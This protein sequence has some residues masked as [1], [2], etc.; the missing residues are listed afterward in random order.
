[1]IGNPGRAGPEC[2]E[3]HANKDRRPDPGQRQR[4]RLSQPHEV[5]QPPGQTLCLF[6]LGEGRNDLRGERARGPH[7]PKP[8]LGMGRREDAALLRE[9][10]GP[11]GCNLPRVGAGQRLFCGFQKYRTAITLIPGQPFQ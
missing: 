7:D 4:E 3:D 11:R 9:P 10:F 8:D 2:K 6:G 1:M 5:E